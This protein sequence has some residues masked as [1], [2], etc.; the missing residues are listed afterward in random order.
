MRKKDKKIKRQIREMIDSIFDFE[1][2]YDYVLIVK[3]AYL[4]NDFSFNREK[5]NELYLKFISRN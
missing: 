5:L 2:Q 1:K 4:E 3:T